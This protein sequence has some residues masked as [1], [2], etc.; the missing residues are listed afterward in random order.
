MEKVWQTGEKK[1]KKTREYA[2]NGWNSPSISS[3]ASCLCCTKKKKTQMFSFGVT[4]KYTLGVETRLLQRL[5]EETHNDSKERSS[6]VRISQLYSQ[7]FCLLVRICTL[8][9]NSFLLLEKQSALRNLV[10]KKETQAHAQTH[11][12]GYFCACH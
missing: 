12:C 7:Y 1:K 5:H 2:K 3:S 8:L 4:Q 10:R 11:T 6:E 9:H